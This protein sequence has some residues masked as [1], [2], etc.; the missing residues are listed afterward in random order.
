MP[1]GASPNQLHLAREFQASQRS[2]LRQVLQLGCAAGLHN[3]TF[4]RGWWR[5]VPHRAK[6]GRTARVA[7]P[8]LEPGRCSPT[9]LDGVVALQLQPGRAVGRNARSST[10]CQR[11]SQ[12]AP[13]RQ[14]PGVTPDPFVN[15]QRAAKSAEKRNLNFCCSQPPNANRRLALDGIPD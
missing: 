7:G 4:R 5:K 14:L 1:I 3:R 13:R 2:I 6:A 11:T 10:R 9:N 15:G 8:L 12:R